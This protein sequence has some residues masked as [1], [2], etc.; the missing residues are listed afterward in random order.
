MRKQA[1]YREWMTKAE[2]KRLTVKGKAAEVN[3][4]ALVDETIRVAWN[5]AIRAAS[6]TAMK[7]GPNG[8]GQ[9]LSIS[10]QE[11]VRLA[12]LK[13]LRPVPKKSKSRRT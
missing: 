2:F 10:Q 11:R 1:T 12:I 5:R 13:L 9:K 7:I 4:F 3:L 6:E 8:M